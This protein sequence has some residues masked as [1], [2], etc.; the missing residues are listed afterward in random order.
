MWKRV[1]TVNCVQD[2]RDE[3]RGVVG[4]ASSDVLVNRLKVV[5]CLRRDD[6]AKGLRHSLPRELLPHLRG[7]LAEFDPLP[8]IELLL[9]AIDCVD[10]AVVEFVS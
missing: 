3:F 4:G 5:C 8:T 6:D 2:A 9:G 1:E 7:E 10:R